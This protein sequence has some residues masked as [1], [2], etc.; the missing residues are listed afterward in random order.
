MFDGWCYF[1]RYVISYRWLV[2]LCFVIVV[3]GSFIGV[4]VGL[5]VCRTFVFDC[6]CY[7]S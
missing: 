5:R 7:N 3:G 1:C 6:E 4:L 2:L